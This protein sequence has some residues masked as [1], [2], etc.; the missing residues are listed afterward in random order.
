M[1]VGQAT[2]GPPPI[3]ALRAEVCKH[4]F[5][6]YDQL[7]SLTGD[8]EA[9]PSVVP[10]A[11]AE[12]G[13]AGG[14]GPTDAEGGPCCSSQQQQPNGSEEAAAVAADGGAC[15]GVGPLQEVTPDDS[16]VAAQELAQRHLDAVKKLPSLRC[17]VVLSHASEEPSLLW[18]MQL[19][20]IPQQ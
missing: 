5:H 18:C 11:A 13:A 19:S 15:E 2:C 4:T 14:M 16:N 7:F 1:I 6:P 17:V 10:D 3:P 9:S 8:G 20:S 12:D